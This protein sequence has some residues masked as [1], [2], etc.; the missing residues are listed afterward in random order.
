MVKPSFSSA[1]LVLF[2]LLTL[3]VSA[4]SVPRQTSTSTPSRNST[5]SST[6]SRNATTSSSSSKKDP[7]AA[8]CDRA[9]TVLETACPNGQ[10]DKNPVPCGCINAFSTAQ[11]KCSRCR[12]SYSESE[13]ELARDAAETSDTF[14]TF[15]SLCIKAGASIRNIDVDDIDLVNT[16]STSTSAVTTL[17]I[18]TPFSIF[19]ESFPNF[20][21][22]V[23]INPDTITAKQCIIGGINWTRC[24]NG[25]VAGLL[26]RVAAYLANL[27][28]G[29]II[30]FSPAES[31]TAVW[32]QLLTVY[33]LLIS[34]LIAIGSSSL[35]RFHSS[36]TIFL[37]MSPLSSTLVV[38]AIQGFCGR[39][40]R[41]DNILSGRREHLLP[42]LLVISYAVLSLFIVIYNSAASTSHFSPNPCE[43]DDVY[44][45]AA[46]VFANLLFV[47][48]AGLVG[49]LLVINN[50]VQLGAGGVIVVYSILA[51]APFIILVCTLIYTIIKQK[52]LL[53]REFRMQPNR[54]KI[55]VTWDVIGE[56]YPFF[57][58]C[59]VFLVPM[60]YWVI[61]NELQ[62]FGTP[63]NIF[64][65]S[66][67]QILA[68]FVILP[69]L[70]QVIFMAPGAWKWFLN[71]SII[72]AMTGRP[73]AAPGI[74][75]IDTLE[76]G[77]IPE[78]PAS[79]PVRF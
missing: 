51:L 40:H 48:Y 73:R 5:T 57:H 2:A 60:I 76:E 49:V 19:D 46:A 8:L 15:R 32:T 54:W 74:T 35:S 14:T 38:Y 37:V 7:C 43:G 13:A 62:T 1:L 12:L 70:W 56:Q 34:G 30:M 47:P 42:R 41:L 77:M 4:R 3:S 9:A 66:F 71:L 28:L 65:V 20:I 58:F 33:S 69:P 63:D 18:E 17:Q 25:D 31:A 67:G 72:C 36:L 68:L 26:V 55:W 27:L 78:K 24:P 10:A 75:R 16:L 45:S 59:G 22:A 44:T 21:T 61:F 52:A 50:L 39:K 53:S 6:S 79:E 64:A 29:I 23:C 11:E